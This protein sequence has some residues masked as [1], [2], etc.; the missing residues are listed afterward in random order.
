MKSQDVLVEWL[1][2]D[3]E[4]EVIRNVTTIT[5]GA[6]ALYFWGGDDSCP[7]KVIR[8]LGSDRI[9]SISFEEDK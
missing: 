6:G 5:V 9:F 2:V 8:D 1:G 7:T 3:T 4:P